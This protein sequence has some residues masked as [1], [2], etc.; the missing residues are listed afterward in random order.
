MM[1]EVQLE[2][3]SPAL[4]AGIKESGCAVWDAVRF[5]CLVLGHNYLYTCYVTTVVR[6]KRIHG[7]GLVVLGIFGE[8]SGT[9]ASD[10]RAKCYLNSFEMQHSTV[11]I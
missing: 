4:S 5:L 8:I 2:G 6:S 1:R 7:E 11:Q 10:F 9:R 3:G